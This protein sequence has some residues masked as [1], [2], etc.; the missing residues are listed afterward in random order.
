MNVDS[1]GRWDVAPRAHPNDG[2][3]DVIDV[4]RSMGLRARWQAWRR[5]P[6]GTHVPHPLIHNSRAT[7]VSWEFERPRRLWLD[8]VARGTVR[9]FTVVVEPDGAVVHI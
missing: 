9:S 7:A 1:L 6:T 3:A 8:G 4:E 2:R 5:L